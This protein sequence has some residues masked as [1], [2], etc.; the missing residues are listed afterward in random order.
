MDRIADPRF[1]E[2]I[3]LLALIGV[4]LILLVLRAR[5]RRRHEQRPMRFRLTERRPEDE[6]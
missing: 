1:L 6:E 3:I 5:K 2:A 4:V